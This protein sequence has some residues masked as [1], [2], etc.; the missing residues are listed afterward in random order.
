MRYEEIDPIKGVTLS[1]PDFES[2]LAFNLQDELFARRVQPDSVDRILGKHG[3]EWEILMRI[4]YWLLGRIH[5]RKVGKRTLTIIC[6]RVGDINTSP[7]A[8][9]AA[10]EYWAR[11]NADLLTLPHQWS[12]YDDAYRMRRCLIEDLRRV[13]ALTKIETTESGAAMIGILSASGLGAAG[14]NIDA[15]SEVASWWNGETR[16]RDL[17]FGPLAEQL[18]IQTSSKVIRTIKHKSESAL[19]CVL[20]TG[21]DKAEL[22]LSQFGEKTQM[23]LAVPPGAMM[24][25][26]GK[27]AITEFVAAVIWRG[28]KK[29]LAQQQTELTT[30]EAQDLEEA[31]ERGNHEARKQLDGEAIR[32]GFK[33]WEEFI[34]S[35]IEPVRKDL[36]D[37]PFIVGY[38]ARRDN[39]K[40]AN[41]PVL[42]VALQTMRSMTFREFRKQVNERMLAN[43]RDAPVITS[44]DESSKSGRRGY[45]TRA[46]KKQAVMDWDATNRN[47]RP[48]LEDWLEGKFGAT[49][50]VLNV[51]PRTF[52]GWRKHLK[53]SR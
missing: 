26:E 19:L 32:Q 3:A 16:T 12:S 20:Q 15:E 1:L 35:I 9:Q 46:E 53:N 41:D 45:G 27:E 23:A 39:P 18:Q 50:G 31:A 2:F 6:V 48:R 36:Q 4:T 52:Q 14:R 44:D 43:L 38:L 21:S 51:K 11:P 47:T 34:V 29:H 24:S 33:T 40:I 30:G 22:S 13:G 37:D 10:R 7:E 42:S 49:G 17:P 28:D 25:A 8:E 5:P